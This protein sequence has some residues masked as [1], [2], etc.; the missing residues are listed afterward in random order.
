MKSA[1]TTCRI[2]LFHSLWLRRRLS[3]V[4]SSIH[5]LWHE[6]LN[7]AYFFAISAWFLMYFIQHW[8]ICRPS[9]ATVSEMLHGIE[10]RTVAT[11]ALAVRRSTHSARS[12]PPT[13]C[14]QWHFSPNLSLYI[15]CN[16]FYLKTVAEKMKW[17]W[18]LVGFDFQENWSR[19]KL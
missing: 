2:R 11:L 4:R 5:S 1:R 7:V 17:R 18:E 19:E 3:F 8:F 10:P 16:I 9:D 12:H 13:R 14:H 6:V 15:N